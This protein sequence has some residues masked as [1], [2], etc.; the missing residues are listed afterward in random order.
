MIVWAAGAFLLEWPA[1]YVTALGA[2]FVAYLAA[3]PWAAAPV[4]VAR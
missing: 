2:A 3:A 4:V 1:P